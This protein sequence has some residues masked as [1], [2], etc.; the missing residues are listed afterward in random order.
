[1]ASLSPNHDLARAVLLDRYA[2]RK[3]GHAAEDTW[4]DVAKRVA[5][6]TAQGDRPEVEGLFRE[7][8]EE[9]YFLPGGRI[10]AAMGAPYRIS[11]MNCSVL[12]SPHDSRDGILNSLKDWVNIQALGCGVGINMSSLRPHG[13]PVKGVNGTSSGPLAWME[14]FSVATHRVVQQGG[15]RR[16]AAMLMLNDS[17]PDILSFIEAKNTPG[18]LEGANLSV[19]VSEEFMEALAA[20]ASWDFR[21]NDAIFG[22]LPARELWSKIIN[23]AWG[24][25]EPGVVFMGRANKMSNSWYFAPLTATNPCA[26]KPMSDNGVCLLGSVNLAR[27]VKNGYM[28][29]PQLEATVALAVRFLD[30]VIDASIYPLHRM[31]ISQKM[32]RQLGIGTMGLADALVACGLKYGS[33]EAISLTEEIFRTIKNAAYFASVS[34]AQ[35]RGSFPAYDRDKFLA[36]GFVKTLAP[37]LRDAIYQHGIRNCFLTSQAPTGS[38]GKVAGVWAGIEPYFDKVTRITNRL[39]TFEFHAP[40]SESLVLA[41]EVTPEQH[42]DMMA[43]AQR[44]IDSAVSKTVNAPS[45]HTVEDTGKVYDLAYERGA[46]S[47]AY[48]RDRSR[49]AQVQWH[50]EEAGTEGL[51][52]CPTCEDNDSC[53]VETV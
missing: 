5:W 11:S 27:H 17:H 7:M 1:M 32:I 13:S 41:N 36:G 48:Y 23:S 25:G 45:Y 6:A 3:N 35:E 38:I 15:S 18:I 14:L 31:M 52:E 44:H 51:G 28:D 50:V 16:G 30:N 29:F 10:L 42:I 4:S 33:P 2:L 43:A 22:S 49:E 9:M 12:P 8:L 47:V 19:G 39:G 20:D 40:D 37:G 34:L 46:K 24:S 26:E 53:L 21:W